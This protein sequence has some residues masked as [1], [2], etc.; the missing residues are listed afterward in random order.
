[1]SVCVHRILRGCRREFLTGCETKKSQLKSKRGDNVI[2]TNFRRNGHFE[3]DRVKRN[4][5]VLCKYLLYVELYTTFHTESITKPLHIEFYF[6]T[7]VKVQ[8]SLINTVQ[9]YE[10]SSQKNSRK[11]IYN[12][13]VNESCFIHKKVRVLGRDCNIRGIP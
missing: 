8:S 11:I 13:V 12:K 7:Y 5:T 10:M 4:E 3:T 2:G 1:M 9:S 6:S